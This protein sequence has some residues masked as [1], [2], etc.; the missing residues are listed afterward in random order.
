MKHKNSTVLK[1]RLYLDID[2][3]LN[4]KI[5]NK[6]AKEKYPDIITLLSNEEGFEKHKNLAHMLWYSVA[7]DNLRMILDATNPDIYIHSSWHYHFKLINFYRFFDFWNL[8][9]HLIKGIVPPY[10]WN[11]YRDVSIKI[12]VEGS[13]LRRIDGYLTDVKVKE[14]TNYV[15]LDDHDLTRASDGFFKE[16]QVIINREKGLTTEDALNAIKMLKQ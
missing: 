6:I 13:R 14:C 9:Y 1:P 2:G 15:I 12:H 10:L 3:V 16:R 5:G 4:C 7:V 11:A 8:D